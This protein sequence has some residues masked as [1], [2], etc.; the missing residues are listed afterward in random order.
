WDGVVALPY[1]IAESYPDNV[2]LIF[3]KFGDTNVNFYRIYGGTSPQPTAL[4]STTPFRLAH[5]S[6]L[7]NN[8]Q[9]YFRVTAVAK[10]GKESGFSNEESVMVNLIQPGQ[11][12]VQNGT[13]AAGTNNWTFVTAN[14]GA[15]TF[16]VVTGACLIHITSAGT[17]LTDL[18]LR[19]SGLKL[20]QGKQYVLEFDGSAIGGN[21]AIDVKLGQDQSPFGIYFTAS[22]TLRITPQHYTYAFTVT[23]AT[24]LNTRLMFNM[25]GIA[26][27]IVLDNISLYM[28]Y[29]SQVAVTLQTLPGGLTVNVDGTNYAAPGSFTWVTNSSHTLSAPTAQ[30]SPDGHARYP[31][32]SWSDGGAETHTVT[33]PRYDTNYTASFSTEFLLDIA[34]APTGGGSVTPM[35]A[36]PWY[37]GNQS[38]SWTSSPTKPPKPP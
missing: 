32:L 4:L 33:T 8:Q 36:G 31:F 23:G 6:N 28:A 37:P 34:V 38:V 12:M 17:A 19:Q 24:D 21:H 22:P 5:L 15:G 9:Y 16:S 14:T 30:L 13:F 35:P 18:Q 1:L 26:R 3:N 7:K 10:D 20:I 27:D 29:D 11:N 25:G 2:T